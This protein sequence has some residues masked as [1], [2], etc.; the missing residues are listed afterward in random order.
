[1]KHNK[2]PWLSKSLIT[3]CKKNIF[4]YKS[5]LSKKT[6]EA[7]SKYRL[8]NNMLTT[9]LIRAE[10]TYYDELLSQNKYNI[11]KN[12]GYIKCYY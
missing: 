2:K 1:M 4:L 3:A 8:Y 11:K 7:E 5:F 6:V 9:I 10:K 12:M